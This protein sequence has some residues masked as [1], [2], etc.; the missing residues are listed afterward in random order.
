[1]QVGGSED[2]LG[3]GNH[4]DPAP[5]NETLRANFRRLDNFVMFAFSCVPI[6]S[7]GSES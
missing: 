7:P 4:L 1:M 2:Y 5:R 6:G 3:K